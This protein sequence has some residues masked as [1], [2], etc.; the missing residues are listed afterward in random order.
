MFRAEIGI[1][2]GPGGRRISLST[3]HCRRSETMCSV[4]VI[5]EERAIS[6][7]SHGCQAC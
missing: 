4:T 2:S 5:L 7:V 6:E 1:G 3:Q